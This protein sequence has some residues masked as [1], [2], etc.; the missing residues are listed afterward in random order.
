MT[1]YAHTRGSNKED[2]QTTLQHLTATAALARELGKDSGLGD[3]AA[4]AARFHDIGKYSLAFQ[5]RLAGS[6]IK[7][8]HATAGAIEI[9]QLY[10]SHGVPLLGRILAYCIAGHHGG[11]PDGGSS[12]DTQ[13]DVSLAGRLKR[14][15]ALEDYS[16]Y[17]SEMD[18]STIHLPRQFPPHFQPIPTAC[19]FS[20]SFATRMIYSTLVDADYLE[21]ETFCNGGKK[22]R[23]AYQQISTLSNQFTA[24]LRRFENP[25]REIDQRRNNTLQACLDQAQLPQGFFTLTLPTGAGKTL[26]SMAFALQHALFHD[27]KRIIYVIP[28][29]SIIE[30]NAAVFRESFMEFG[31][32]VLE[33]HSSFEWDQQREESQVGSYNSALVK[34]KWAAENWDVPIVVTTNVQFFESL[35]ANRSSRARKLHNLAKSIIIFDEAQMLPRE[36]MKPCMYAV[37]ELV[38]NYGVTAVFCTATQPTVERFLPE[39]HKLHELI[40][41]PQSEFNFYRRVQVHFI[42][43]ITDAELLE[44]LNN[45]SQMLCIVNTRKHAR[46]LFAEMRGDSCFHLSTLMCPTHR[47]QT[48][49]EIRRRLKE[50]LPCRVISTQLLE[51]GVDLDFPVGYRAL[52]G[53]DSIIQSAGR[54]NRENNL[55]TAPLYVF[56]PDSEHART[57]PS[58]IRQTAGVAKIVIDNYTNRDPI[59]I[60]AIRDY[61]EQ[62]Y[63]LSAPNAFDSKNILACFEKRGSPFPF[64]FATAA[65]KFRLIENDTVPV[66]VPYDAEIVRVLLSELQDTQTPLSVVRKLQPYTVNIYKP[67]YDALDNNGAIDLYADTYA[68]LNHRGTYSIDTGLEL[69][70]QRGGQAVFMD[71]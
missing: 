17:T 12:I 30:Q 31:D 51:A 48:I 67:E 4:I 8:D 16:A 63:S 39:R 14:S 10:K 53:L 26:T 29:T 5:K 22:P 40:A 66:I 20:I 21:T 55:S 65:K 69:M 27:L 35:F 45:H 23:G 68:V 47:K 2:W 41:N 36:F 50:G 28:Y 11:L 18:L 58:Y 13:D 15:S 46:A 70:N 57:M 34:L 60:E 42:G 6:S 62:L 25:Q 61:Y 19:G 9:E 7:V 32:H 56:E 24:Y 52:A 44:R 37:T 38:Q 71:A 59:S 54:V 3:F 43:R 1:F 49:A 33:H 64:D